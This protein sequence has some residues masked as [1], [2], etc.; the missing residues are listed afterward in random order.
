[1]SSGEGLG[2]FAVGEPSLVFLVAHGLSVVEPSGCAVA[3]LVLG[4]AGFA[5][6][7]AMPGRAVCALGGVA[8]LALPFMDPSSASST[9]ILRRRLCGAAATSRDEESG[10]ARR[11]DSFTSR[12]HPSGGGVASRPR[13]V[14]LLEAVRSGEIRPAR[15]LAT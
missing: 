4:D 10:V 15:S 8:V 12:E 3:P 2:A 1:M 6:V 9:V 7:E 5:E 14:V 13:C 11:R